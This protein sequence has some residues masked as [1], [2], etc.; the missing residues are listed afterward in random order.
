MY[1]I[2]SAFKSMVS[3]IQMSSETITI[4]VEEIYCC[5]GSIYRKY[6]VPLSNL[7]SEDLELI[8]ANT[9]DYFLEDCLTQIRERVPDLKA[10]II[11]V[12]EY[13]SIEIKRC[14]IAC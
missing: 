11:N 9:S 6:I 12:N 4:A 5:Q 3:I 8:K 7:L 14:H 13:D 10:V 2:S 1:D